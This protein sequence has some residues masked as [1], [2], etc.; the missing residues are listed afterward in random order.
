MAGRVVVST[1]N[2]DTGVLATQNGMT[3]IAKAW[4]LYNGVAQ[5]VTASFN[6]SSVTYNGTGDYTFNF[7]TVMPSANYAGTCLTNIGNG[8]TRADNTSSMY[9]QTA[10]AASFRVGWPTDI[11]GNFSSVSIAILSS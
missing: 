3:G 4:C 7:T 2:D 11:R 8:Q 1:L 6:V 5:T 9:S 10:S